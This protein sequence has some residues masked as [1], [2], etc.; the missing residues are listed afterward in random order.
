MRD[1]HAA[2]VPLAPRQLPVQP[3][4]EPH[5]IGQPGRGIGQGDLPQFV[6]PADELEKAVGRGPAE[7]ARNIASKLPTACSEGGPL[8]ALGQRLQLVQDID[9]GYASA[10]RRL[11]WSRIKTCYR[12]SYSH[13]HPLRTGTRPS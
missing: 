12:S 13:R 5:A 4:E 2:S 11:R 3:V 8:V 1:D 10:A 7:V 9:R 6:V